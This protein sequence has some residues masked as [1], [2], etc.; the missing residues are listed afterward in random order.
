MQARVKISRRQK[1]ILGCGLGFVGAI[2]LAAAIVAALPGTATPFMASPEV[3]SAVEGNT[4]FALDLYQKLKVQPGNLFF[5]PYSI[6]SALA[7]T[8]AGA[9]KQTES[10]MARTLHFSLPQEKLHP[11]FGALSARMNKVQRWNRITL[12][13]ANSLW[14]E[15]DY[16]FVNTFLNLVRA[17]YQGDARQVDFKN[18]AQAACSEIND[19]VQG[20]TK[21]RIKGVI[22]PGQISPDTRLIL[23]NAIYFKGRWQTQFKTEDTRPMPF[24]VE[25]NQTVTVPMMRQESPFKITIDDDDSV[26]MLELPYSGADLSMII[27]LPMADFEKST[28]PDLEQKLTPKNLHAWLEKLDQTG[29]NKA[30]VQL[31]RF[32]TTQSFD[33]ANDLKSLGMSSAFNSN[34]DFSGMETTTNLFISGVIHKAF[35][36]VNEAGTEA[37]AVA[38]VQAKTKSQPNSFNANHPFIFLLREN[39]SGTILFLGR[40][41]DPT[42]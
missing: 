25:T 36:E 3:K 30:W 7:M 29:L 33:L 13:T 41:V 28:L 16:P 40:V 24:F 20:K 18:S 38:W 35:V 4:A 9:R 26:E 34:A 19:W 17:N 22:G 11:A 5:S 12:T 37:A 2:V 1:L 15:Q 14:C 21:G 27:L 32:A 23:C 42:K 10:E 8:W 39:G 31:P 6:S